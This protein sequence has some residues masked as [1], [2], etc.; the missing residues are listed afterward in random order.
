MLLKSKRPDYS[1]NH[2]MFVQM[3]IYFFFD[4]IQK[5]TQ[6]QKNF[7]TRIEENTQKNRR[8]IN[9]RISPIHSNK[10]ETISR[11]NQI[12]LKILMKNPITFEYTFMFDWIWMQCLVSGYAIGA[13]TIRLQ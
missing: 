13:K 6:F 8:Q 7:I 5:Q 4:K 9:T 3:A 11:C 10:V 1:I 12:L 2:N